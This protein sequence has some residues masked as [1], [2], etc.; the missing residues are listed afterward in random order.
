MHNT[1]K[2]YYELRAQITLKKLFDISL[3]HSDRPD[4]VSE[5]GYGIEIT[6][7][8]NT[9]QEENYKF[10]HNKM[11]NNSIHSIP[12]KSLNRF[13]KDNLEVLEIDNK[14]IGYTGFRWHSNI[15]VINA[16][17]HKINLINQDGYSVNQIDLYVF[18]DDFKQYDADDVKEIMTEIKVYQSQYNKHMNKVF[19]DDTGYFYVIDLANE[20]IEFINTD[21]YLS[22]IVRSA[23]KKAM[24][25][26]KSLH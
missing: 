12:K 24:L 1:E 19:L 15:N 21:P 10:F 5:S 18:T 3:E 17:K 4:L 20:K 8:I 22:E 9:T 6:R 26:E 16:I 25:I 2:N 7:A 14:I 13:E 23:K 11:K